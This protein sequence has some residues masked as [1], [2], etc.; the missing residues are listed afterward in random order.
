LRRSR[1]DDLDGLAVDESKFGALLGY[2]F[3]LKTN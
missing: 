2:V 3:V 1:L